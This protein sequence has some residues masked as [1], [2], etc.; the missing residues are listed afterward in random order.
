[1]KNVNPIDLPTIRW[2]HSQ[3]KMNL[4][5]S[6]VI[7]LS[8]FVW[9]YSGLFL[10]S[11]NSFSHSSLFIGGNSRL[12]SH[13]TIDKPDLVSR[14]YPPT[15]TMKKMEEDM[16]ANHNPT[17]FSLPAITSCSFTL[18]K[19]IGLKTMLSALVD[20]GAPLLPIVSPFVYIRLGKYRDKLDKL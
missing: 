19:T 1:M 5:P 10:Y 12:G 17:A 13:L 6:T 7:P 11:S 3:K 20:L 2:N 9:M 15:Q 16:P 14:V 8:L 18:L 4:N